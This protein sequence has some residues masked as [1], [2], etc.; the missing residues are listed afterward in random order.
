LHQVAMFASVDIDAETLAF[1]HQ[2]FFVEEML[3]QDNSEDFVDLIENEP[4]GA[5]CN[6]IIQKPR[7][8]EQHLTL[9]VEV[10]VADPV[11]GNKFDSR[12]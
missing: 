6:R 7:Y 3:L 11:L 8:A 1:R 9:I 4:V 2:R 10:P 12:H 5:L